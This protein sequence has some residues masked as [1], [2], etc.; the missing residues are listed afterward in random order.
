M[1]SATKTNETVNALGQILPESINVVVNGVTI[2]APGKPSKSGGR[3]YEAAMDGSLDTEQAE[4][5][6]R[7]LVCSY[8][9]TPLVP[10]LVHKSQESKRSKGGNLTVS[11]TANVVVGE[12]GV[13]Y[14]VRVQATAVIRKEK[15]E[16]G[17]TVEVPK[18]NVRIKAFRLGSGGGKKFQPMGTANGSLSF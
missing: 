12:S 3:W 8:E 9:G 16:D 13:R 10:S 15:N 11:H 6:L 2:N 5:A 14:S 1:T 4:D 7:R 17:E 18:I